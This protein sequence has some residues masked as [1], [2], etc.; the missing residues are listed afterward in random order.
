M[1]LFVHS[2]KLIVDYV[3]LSSKKL[4]NFNISSEIIGN[5]LMADSDNNEKEE[6]MMY[7]VATLDGHL[8]LIRDEEII[9]YTLMI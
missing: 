1:F 7:A 2:D 4:R 3:P 9:W 5:L 8:M 6:G